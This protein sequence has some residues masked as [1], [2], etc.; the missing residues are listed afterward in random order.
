[1]PAD[2]SLP[3]TSA[4]A[5]ADRALPSTQAGY[6][7]PG[8]RERRAMLMRLLGTYGTIIVL[9]SMLLIFS[10]LQ[11]GTFATIG[12]FRN[13]IND[14]A[15]GTIVAAGL[16]VPLVAGD[17]DLSIGYVA[18]FCGLLVVGLLSYGGLSIPVAIILVVGLGTLIGIVNGIVVSKIGVNA[19]IATLGTGTIVV[20]L[21]YAYSGGI[22]LQLT[23]SREFTGIAIGRIAGVPHLVIIMAAVLAL[24]WVILN[25]TVQGQHIKAIGVSPE[26]ARRAGVAVDRSRIVAFAIA[27]TC[28]A[29]GGVLMA[30]NLG[31]GQVTAGDG[32]MLTSFSA[33]FLGSA[34]LREGQFHILGTLIGVLTVAVGNNGLA[35]IGAPIFTQF[36]FTGCLLVVAVALGGI[37]RR[38]ARG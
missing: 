33:A 9:G 16:T 5:E 18:S 36:L 8:A 20:G 3:E 7:S 32:F 21:N 14:M 24:L 2:R 15:I 25:R 37:G 6:P 4:P 31:S 35:M 11:P 10:V 22:P 23:Q 1:M 28:A 34:A 30:S 26:S 13:I 29:V 17:F 12:N 19:F 27:S 38:Y